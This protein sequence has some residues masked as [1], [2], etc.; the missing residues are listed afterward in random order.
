MCT[1]AAA[2]VF[3]GLLA[4]LDRIAPPYD[5]LR[6][7]LIGGGV[8]GHIRY[9]LD[10]GAHQTSPHGP[11]GIA[12]Y[13]WGW[14]VDIKPILYLNINPQRPVPGLFGVHPQAHFLGMI[15]PAI[16]LVGLPGLAIAAAG[17]PA[18]ASGR[19]DP[20]RATSSCSDWRGL[21]GHSCRSCCSA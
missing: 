13:P 17:G 18:C 1:A 9:M 10:Y 7:K 14:L 16:L 8:F 20:P 2:A 12:S 4:L 19:P 21:Q 15:S 5:P 3:V 6:H 11:Q